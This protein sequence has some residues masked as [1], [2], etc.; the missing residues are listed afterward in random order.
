[1]QLAT[2][3]LIKEYMPLCSKWQHYA[4]KYFIKSALSI[5]KNWHKIYISD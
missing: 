3:P 4:C 1:M 2:I 5:Y